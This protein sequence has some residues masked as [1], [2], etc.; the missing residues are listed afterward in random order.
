MLSLKFRWFQ[1]FELIGVWLVFL[2]L[3]L[4]VKTKSIKKYK[5][6]VIEKKTIGDIRIGNDT[7]PKR[8]GECAGLPVWQEHMNCRV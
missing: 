5:K 4:C 1:I 3:C 2:L 6:R 8:D 7:Q